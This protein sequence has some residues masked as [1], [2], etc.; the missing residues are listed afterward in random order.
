MG[1]PSKEVEEY[2]GKAL[3]AGNV[4]KD[5]IILVVTL[6]QLLEKEPLEVQSKLLDAS[7]WLQLGFRNWNQKLDAEIN[8]AGGVDVTDPKS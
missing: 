3:Q 7:A 4:P 5:T 8:K 6:S 2:I 1:P